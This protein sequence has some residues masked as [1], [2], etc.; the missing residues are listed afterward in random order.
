MIPRSEALVMSVVIGE[1]MGA[2]SV[3]Q[4]RPRNQDLH[5]NKV[6]VCTLTS[7]RHY[8]SIWTK[9]VLFISVEGSR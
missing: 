3:S 9:V 2:A 7:E 4:P 1:A 6:S 5:F 8:F